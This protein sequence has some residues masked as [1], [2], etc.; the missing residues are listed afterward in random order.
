MVDPKRHLGLAGD[1]DTLD[2]VS[3]ARVGFDAVDTVASAAAPFATAEAVKSL[4][5]S[6]PPGIPEVQLDGYTYV[7]T[8]IYGSNITQAWHYSSGAGVTIALVDDGFDSATTGTF[9]NFSSSLSSAVGTGSGTDLSEPVGSAHG[10]TT[11]GLIAGSGQNDTPTGLAPNATI[12]GVKVDFSTAGIATLAQAEQRAASVA[13]VVNNSWGYNGY[14]QGEPNDPV[15]AV[16]Y[17]AIQSAVSTGRQGLGD[18][19]T[20]AAGNDRTNRQ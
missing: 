4:T 9:V 17:A 10:T 8:T 5:L 14:A 20:V 1:A 2:W 15:F 13:S 16:W 6:A 18:V 3:P 19:I 11:A 7:K 12:V